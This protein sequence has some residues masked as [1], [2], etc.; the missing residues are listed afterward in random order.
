MKSFPIHLIVSNLFQ[1]SQPIPLFA[2]CCAFCFKYG[3]KFEETG[4]LQPEVVKIYNKS[5]EEFFNKA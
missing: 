3:E 4:S 2:Q 1:L 5:L